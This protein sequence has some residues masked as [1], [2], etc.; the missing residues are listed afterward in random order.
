MLM[1]YQRKL[2]RA[3][4]KM[5]YTSAGIGFAG[6]M[7]YYAAQSYIDNS[8]VQTNMPAAAMG[9]IVVGIVATVY[10]S[11]KENAMKAEYAKRK[12]IIKNMRS[13]LGTHKSA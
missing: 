10:F 3:Y 7:M 5:K 4:Q 13:E 9:V 1:R 11:I 12:E 6:V 8:G 2:I